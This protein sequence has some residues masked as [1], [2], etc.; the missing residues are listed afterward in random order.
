[1]EAP[2]EDLNRCRAI[3]IL[4]AAD[5]DQ[6]AVAGVMHCHKSVVG[7][8]EHW[9]KELPEAE[10]AK[11][12]YDQALKNAFWLQIMTSDKQVEYKKLGVAAQMDS[13]YL[14]NHYGKLKAAVKKSLFTPDWHQHYARLTD[15]AEKLRLNVK[16]IKQSKGTLLGNV[17]AGYIQISKNEQQPLRNVDRMDVECL[18]SHLKATFFQFKDIDSWENLTSR[19]LVVLK[20]SDSLGKILKEVSYGLALK[21]MCKICSSW[22]ETS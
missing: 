13:D 3:L 19:E 18:L 7:S 6:D 15:A 17:T 5:C 22:L 12:C 8:V 2:L 20:V 16:D 4:R 1:M 9:F 21:G 14:L 11:F 10:A